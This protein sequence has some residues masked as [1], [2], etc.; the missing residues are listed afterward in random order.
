VDPFG[1]IDRPKMGRASLPKRH[2]T[3]FGTLIS[4]VGNDMWVIGKVP[5][6]PAST[7]LWNVIGML[8]EDFTER[9]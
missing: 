1:K 9:L 5:E 8:P 2:R 7:L 4:G 6:R 3:L